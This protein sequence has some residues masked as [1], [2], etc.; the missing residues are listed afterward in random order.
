MCRCVIY[1][2]FQAVTTLFDYPMIFDLHTGQP[3]KNISQSDTMMGG[4]TCLLTSPDGKL[5]V[6]G[7]TDG[8]VRVTDLDGN[9]LFRMQHRSSV[10]RACFSPDSKQLLTAGFRN[11]LVWSM[12]NGKLL[13]SLSRHT[14]FVTKMIFVCDGAYLVTCGKDKQI[15]IWDMSR[16]VTVASFYASGPV[17]DICVARDLSFVI[18]TPENVAYLGILRPNPILQRICKGEATEDLPEGF[19]KAQA[20]A[21]TFSS[22]KVASSTSQTCALL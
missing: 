1:H 11:I 21:L 18:Y 17:E 6:S 5:L 10:T 7:S 15:L 13:Y 22:Q 16:K 19:Q 3:L 14:D 4:C 12:D 9:Y 20:V 2:S 8:S